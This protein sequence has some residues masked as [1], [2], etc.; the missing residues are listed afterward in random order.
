MLSNQKNDAKYPLIVLNNHLKN[1]LRAP[2]K[3]TLFILFA[4]FFS[5]IGYSANAMVPSIAFAEAVDATPKPVVSAEIRKIRR[6]C[7][8]NLGLNKLYTNLSDSEK[9]AMKR[10]IGSK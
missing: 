6:E 3:Q 8:I 1:R 2:M 5:A 10:C 4:I 9:E 7:R